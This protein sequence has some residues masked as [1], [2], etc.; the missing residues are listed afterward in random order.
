MDSQRLILFFVFS[1]SIFFLLD[2]WQRDQQPAPKTVT[3]SADKPGASVAPP[4]PTPSNKLL[5]AQEAK[6]PGTSALA[7][8]ETI[9][10]ETDILR[11]EV[12]TLGGDLRRL[13]FK[14]HRDTVDK[15]KNFVLFQNTPQHVYVAQSGLI[16]NDMPNHR[17]VYAAQNAQYTLG[18]GDDVLEVRLEASGPQGVRAAK[19]Y[20]FR[21]AS[22]VI[23]V[24]YQVMNHGATTIQPFGYFQLVRDS[25][26]PEGD[27]AMVPTYTGAAVYTEKDKFQ[28]VDFGDIDK[29]KT[30][31]PKNANDGWVA[32]V[33]HYFLSAW[34]PKNGTPR[35]FYTRK[36]EGDLYAAGVIVPVGNVE[37]GTTAALTV[38]LYAGPQEQDKLAKLAP[39][40][41]LTVDYGW[42]TVIAVPLFWVLSWFHEWVGNWG[43]AIILLTV[44]IKLLFYPLSEASYR[45]M[46]KMRVLAPKM[47]RLKEQYGNDRQRMQQAMM[48][49]YKTEKINPLGG[50]L[51]I[52]VQIPVFIAL[53][54]VLLASV[55]LRHAPLMLW[56][57]DLAAPDPWF[58][59]PIL[60]GAT[61]IIQTRLNPEPPDPVQAKVMKIMPIAFSIFFF[62]FPAG[63]VLYWLVN[64]VLSIAQQWHI[65]RVLERANL[66]PSRKG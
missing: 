54:W 45:S 23:E 52:I 41:D 64:N 27:S 39:G 35:E 50:C 63:L 13:E 57:Q 20:R 38:P 9:K 51:P 8:G 62:F 16:G 22:Y 53:Y 5:S 29:G 6:P 59:L 18:Q 32:L 60:M 58:V 1:I 36:L 4:V 47:Q 15:A 40:L 44:L 26:S 25:K 33:Q 31:Y 17:T 49:L 7:T 42:L 34:L 12:S 24:T 21:R 2:A 46:A 65:N 10:I 19:I 56:I 55:E 28:K 43:I 66:R 3:Q 11:A 37:P 30:P 14:A 48:E 61:M